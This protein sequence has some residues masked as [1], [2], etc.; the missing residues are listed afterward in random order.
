MDRIAKDRS[1][2]L[3]TP[4]A[5]LPARFLPA[6]IALTLALPTATVPWPAAAQTPDN[7]IAA[8]AEPGRHA[9]RS[10]PAVRIQGARPVIDGDLSDPVW[11]TAPVATGFV[12]ML[13]RAGE[14]ASERTEARVLYDDEA[15]YVAI[16]AWDSR[17]DSVTGQLTRRDEASYSDLVY[18]MVD[19][20]F[21]RR[22]AFR[23]AANPV[24]V[25]R[26]SYF[27]E[28]AQQDAGWQAVWDVATRI[29]DEGWTAEF[30][31][32][33][34][35]LRFSG[36]PVQ[37]W[38]INFGREIA[39]RNEIVTWSPLVPSDPSVVSRAGLLTGIENLKPAS[40][41]ELMPY[42]AGSVT[43]AP[44]DPAN[45]FWSS[46]AGALE[47]GADLRM[48]VTSDLTLDLTLNPDFGQ[49]E[50]DPAQVNLTAFETFLPERRPF[51]QEGASIFR[52]GIGMGDGDGGN[53]GLFYSRRIGRAPQGSAPG[54]AD[55]VDMP[56]QTR[57]LSAGKLSGKTQ[58]GWSIGLLSAVT[59]TEKARALAD[60][61]R[62]SNTVEPWA[63][64]SVAR[65][66]KDLG[67]GETSI[68]GIATATF[69]DGA[70]ADD[71]ELHR[72]AFSGG[73]DLR[74]RFRGGT[75]EV[76][77]FLLGSRVEGSPASVL[78]TQMSSARYFQ[79]P[80][81]EHVTL[82]P[83]AT[84]M[85]GWSGKLE[86]WK[87]GGGPWRWASLT[88][89][90]SPGF[91]VN[92]LGFMP[93]S[94]YVS[95]WFWL[96]YR[97]DRPGDRL[98]RWGLNFN[99]GSTWTFGGERTGGGANVN[100]NGS[101]LGNTDFW[102]GLNWNSPGFSP[103]LLRGGPGIRVE[104]AMSGWGGF[105]SDGRRDVQLNLNTSWSLRPE[106]DSWSAHLSP[107]LRWRP[108][109]RATL[110][111]GPSYTR[112][113]EGRQ[114]VDRVSVD[115]GSEYVF[116]RMEQ[117]T[118]GMTL[119]ADLA[120]TPALSLQLYAQPFV[121]SGRFT[122]FHR[123]ADPRARRHD[124]RFQSVDAELVDG[125]YLAD[126]TGDG[127]TESFRNPEFSTM[128]FRSNAVLRW[129]YRPGSTAWLV[130]AQGRNAFEADGAF[131]AGRRLGDLFST[132]AQNILMVK[133]SYWV[134]P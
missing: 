57:I 16:R 119:R 3:P 123:V 81:A 61:E 1:V 104:Q 134:N 38:G 88:H 112:R 93:D 69:R 50:A 58:G 99:T 13:P 53:Q 54:G 11:S 41:L 76:R 90:R 132:G 113:S 34:S 89:L 116:G 12:Q 45:P 102:G 108:S 129:E 79:R 66:Q 52:M 75:M 39:R 9:L 60:G 73:L 96:A 23:F 82:D 117:N 107:Q 49:V 124:D 100:W 17:P 67:G 63:N 80:D 127:A 87:L 55:W 109:G 110:R 85:D 68:G 22:T 25:K 10:L 48:G 72:R 18:V 126:L 65:I 84:S 27:Y 95:Q 15:L 59:D 71:L 33:L 31:I 24:G 28:D 14:P 118:L 37:T 30:R 4:W 32:P 91:E 40:R 97:R 86:L 83:A 98:R 122:G 26:D 131:D 115:D 8:D 70:P 46:T 120:M 121:S 20:Y 74:H 114:W 111:A 56:S 47:F 130:W 105:A 128:Q 62:I 5:P 2:A 21:D 94:D 77:S 106:S 51:F 101:T 29:D 64:Y 125:R 103:G 78:R 35:Q 44:G 43:R 92:D 36:A 6:L 19:S 42:S 133:V 7:G